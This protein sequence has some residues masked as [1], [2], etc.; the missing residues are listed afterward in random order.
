M[1]KVKDGILLK[2]AISIEGRNVVALIDS[3]ASHSYIAPE[4]I[5]ICEL[6]CVPSILHLE[7]ADGSRIE[8]TKQQRTHCV[9]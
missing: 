7:L 5:A 4:T 1:R 2:V 3:G 8:S 6:K 9:Y